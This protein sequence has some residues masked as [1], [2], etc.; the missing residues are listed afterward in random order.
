M[1]TNLSAG[2]AWTIFSCAWPFYITFWLCVIDTAYNA[3]N[4]MRRSNRAK[5]YFWT[6]PLLL[7][8]GII[9]FDCMQ[10]GWTFK[11]NQG[12]IVLD[13]VANPAKLFLLEGWLVVME[14]S[15]RNSNRAW[16]GCL[17]ISGSPF[18]NNSNVFSAHGMTKST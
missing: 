14:G 8:T 6:G 7:A 2:C 4:A 15:I 11:I 12:S 1:L 17:Y 10:M 18:W 5:R 3:Y 16:L 13:Y 9:K